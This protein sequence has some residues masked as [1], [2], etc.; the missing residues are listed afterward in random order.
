MDFC[1]LYTTFETQEQAESLSKELLEMGWIAC[2]NVFPPMKSF[3]S[4]KGKVE[5][6]EE[7]A[8][9]LKTKQENWKKIENWIYENHPYDCPCLIQ[10]SLSEVSKAYSEWLV[11]QLS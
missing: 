2:A 6:S 10:L 7:V 5:A 1:F 3:Y 4:W 9:I 11:N 8:A